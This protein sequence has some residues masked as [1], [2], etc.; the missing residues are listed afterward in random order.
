MIDAFV[1]GRH[2]RGMTTKDEPRS[3]SIASPAGGDRLARALVG[4][5]AARVVVALATGVAAEAARRHEAGPAAAVAMGRAATAGLLLAT[6]TKDDERVTLQ[7]LGKGPLGTLTVDA[8]SSGTAR[9]FVTNPRFAM[10][11]L[12]ADGAPGIGEAVGRSGV[13][14]VVRDLG[15]G[16]DFSGQTPIVDGQVDTD[17]EHYLCQS[18]QIDS[19][20]G[21]D[22]RLDARGAVRLSVG[23]LVQA[24]PH[25]EG[26][27]HVAAARARLRAGALQALPD[28]A[29]VETIIAA[30]LGEDVAQARLLPG[31]LPLRFHCPCSRER[32]AST[33]ALLGDQDLLALISEEGE[34]DVT[35]EFCRARYDF[36]DASLEAIRQA[37]RSDTTLPS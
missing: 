2:G 5:G 36:N 14:N 19:A 21:C 12:A 7:L 31:Q 23:V 4:D 26:S 8:S 13:V 24:L 6:L 28:D 30:V 10:Q 17:V 11:E 34:A 37:L 18:E 32:A 15:P 25:S 1:F 22:T 29:D 35:C 33:L 3:D 27:S 9:V 20:L 16:H